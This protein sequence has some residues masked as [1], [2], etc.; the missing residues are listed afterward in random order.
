M[1]CPERT[2]GCLCRIHG[3]WCQCPT[4]VTRLAALSLIMHRIV[5][6]KRS[7]SGYWKRRCSALPEALAVYGTTQSA[8]IETERAPIAQ[9]STWRPGTAPTLLRRRRAQKYTGCKQARYRA[10]MW[11]GGTQDRLQMMGK[12]GIGLCIANRASNEYMFQRI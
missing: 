4:K 2:A 1:G 12:G 9:T 3:T 10:V 7:S 5:N 6:T 11:H 8:L